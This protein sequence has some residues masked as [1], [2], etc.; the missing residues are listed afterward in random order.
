MGKTKYFAQMIRAKSREEVE[1]L[2]RDLREPQRRYN[3]RGDFV[4]LAPTMTDNEIR[5]ELLAFKEEDVCK[6]WE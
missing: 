2:I 5:M 4:G 1:Q 6:V 3:D